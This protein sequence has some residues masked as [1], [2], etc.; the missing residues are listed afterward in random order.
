MLRICVRGYRI[1][2][3][4]VSLLPEIDSDSVD[5]E[6]LA[7]KER[8]KEKDSKHLKKKKRMCHLSATLHLHP[9]RRTFPMLS[10]HLY[11][12]NEVEYFTADD[13]SS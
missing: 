9:H 11:H 12:R 5:N 8:F 10:G 3:P 4:V 7:I 6:H 13:R 1:A 2:C